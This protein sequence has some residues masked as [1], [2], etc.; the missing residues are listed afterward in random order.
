MHRAGEHRCTTKLKV[1][2]A[3][4]KVM[5]GWLYRYADVQLD[6]VEREGWTTVSVKAK[7]IFASYKRLIS[8]CPASDKKNCC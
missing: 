7:H 1:A 6:R 2:A 3:K 5:Y 4:D 8:G